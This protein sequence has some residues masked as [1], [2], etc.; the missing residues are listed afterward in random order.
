MFVS[1]PQSESNAL[2]YKR[3]RKRKLASHWPSSSQKHILAGHQTWRPTEG[4]DSL[5]SLSLSFAFYLFI[6]AQFHYTRL[7]AHFTLVFKLN[8]WFFWAAGFDLAVLRLS[9]GVW[10]THIYSSWHK[11]YTMFTLLS[12][13]ISVECQ[14]LWLQLLLYLANMEI[15]H[16]L[17]ILKKKVFLW[18]IIDF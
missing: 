17:N 14:F 1:L 4:Q 2:R 3:I 6:F 12:L 5:S 16:L 11:T 10:W 9:A 15:L 13:S 18:K 7:V 8:L